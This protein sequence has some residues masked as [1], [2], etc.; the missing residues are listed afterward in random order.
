VLELLTALTEKSLLVAESEGAPRY[1]MLGTIKEYAAQRLAEA[2]ETDLARQAHLAYF[3]ELAETAEPRLRRAEQVDWLTTLAA[4]HDNLGSAM[5]GAL[6]AG[7][8]PAA[9]RLAQGVGW[10]WWLSGHKAE[11]MELLTAATETP[12]EVADEVRATVYGL[13]SMFVSSGLSDEHAA[14]RWIHEAYRLG[15]GAQHHH[16]ALRLVVPLE[17]ML[18]APETF[19]A[20]WESLLDDEDPWVRA[21]ARMQHAKMRIM[22]GDGGRDAD[23]ELETAL[24]EFRALGERFGI[25]FAQTELAERIATRGEFAGA[26]EH[27]DQAIAVVTEVGALDDVIR[28]RSR[29]ALLYWL[30][31]DKEAVAAAI[32]EAERYARRVTWPGTLAILALA[33]AELARR[34]GDAGEVHRQL[35]VA[36]TKLGEEADRAYIQATVQDLLGYLAD[37]LDT[38][39]EHRAAALRAAT[40]A[41][42]A[43]LIAQVLVGIADLALRRD[44]YEQAARLL[45][46]SAGARGLPDLAHPDLARIEQA[47]RNRLGEAKFAE[48]VREGTQSSWD[49]VAAVTLAS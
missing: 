30:L 3:T 48:A 31:E 25:S 37:D 12:G 9:M 11:G 42:H 7:D 43:T 24:A 35:A 46:A 22:L 39:R 6:A 17:R 41:G 1:R 10:Y 8:G 18:T 2:G 26:C 23:A 20:A 13:I 44:Q 19:L 45:A 16:P 47:A 5:R 14:A 29:Q 27:Y 21:L 36:T 38:A 28:M 32:A 4:D 15:R 49:Q 40:E 33:K 34:G